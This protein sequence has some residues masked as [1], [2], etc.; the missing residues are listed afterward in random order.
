[1]PQGQQQSGYP[2]GVPGNPQQQ[3]NPPNMQQ[4][5]GNSGPAQRPPG[6]NAPPGMA[7][8]GMNPGMNGPMQGYYPTGDRK[9]CSLSA[10]FTSCVMHLS[11]LFETLISHVSGIFSCSAR[12]LRSF[13]PCLVNKHIPVSK[14][15]SMF[16]MCLSCLVFKQVSCLK[17]ATHPTVVGAA[18]ILKCIL[19]VD[20]LPLFLLDGHQHPC[21]PMHSDLQLHRPQLNRL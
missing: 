19:L 20:T 10:S 6:M 21:H 8:P 2:L 17:A 1:M 3:Q 16:G 18:D 4:N 11:I 9:C 14:C 13:S 15:L 5:N 12:F 7:P